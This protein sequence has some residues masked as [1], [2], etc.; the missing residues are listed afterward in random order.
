MSGKDQDDIAKELKVAFKPTDGQAAKIV[1][2]I[3]GRARFFHR[4]F[5]LMAAK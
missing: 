1:R 2:R 3:T 4:V 5:V